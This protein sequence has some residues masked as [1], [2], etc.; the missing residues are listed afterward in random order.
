MPLH[1]PF[2]KVLFKG[3]LSWNGISLLLHK[4]KGKHKN[5]TRKSFHIEIIFEKNTGSKIKS[6]FCS[7]YPSLGISQRCKGRIWDGTFVTMQ[8]TAKYMNPSLYLYDIVFWKDIFS[9]FYLLF[10]TSTLLVPIHWCWSIILKF[11][12]ES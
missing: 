4:Y 2:L 11:L 3:F 6:F 8:Y 10:E 1:M 5:S 12:E 9:N 7:H